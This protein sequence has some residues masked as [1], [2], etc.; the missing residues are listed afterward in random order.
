MQFSKLVVA[1]ALYRF[2]AASCS[3]NNDAGRWDDS[4]AP[5]DRLADLCGRGGGCYQAKIGHM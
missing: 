5:A 1:G 3:H 4:L 2:A